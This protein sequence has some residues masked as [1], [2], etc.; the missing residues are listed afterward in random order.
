MAEGAYNENT[1]RPPIGDAPAA[2][3]ARGQARGSRANEHTA[4][5]RTHDTTD[6]IEAA[7]EDIVPRVAQTGSRCANL[8]EALS[9]LKEVVGGCFGPGEINWYPRGSTSKGLS[10]EDRDNGIIPDIDVDLLIADTCGVWKW[11]DSEELFEG[12]VNRV[13]EMVPGREEIR[14]IE[15]SKESEPVTRSFKCIVRKEGCYRY[16]VDIFPKKCRKSANGDHVHFSWYS[17]KYNDDMGRV[18]RNEEV[19]IASLDRPLPEFQDT[20]K[21]RAIVFVK[22][23]VKRHHDS[24]SAKSYHLIL[25]AQAELDPD[26]DQ[27]ALFRE[28]QDQGTA[29]Q[30]AS[31]IA[32]RLAAIRTLENS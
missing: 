14:G 12:A 13:A 8:N 16:E 10:I 28:L 4:Q 9:A 25:L 20:P 15:V 32:V 30:W 11:S 31:M 23:Q 19:E 3:V 24:F 21:N 27:Y 26:E 1:A 17:R 6:D 22:Y 5:H 2:P 7:I 18:A 29:A